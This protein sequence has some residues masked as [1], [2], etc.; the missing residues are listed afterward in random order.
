MATSY[1]RYAADVETVVRLTHLLSELLVNR[2]SLLP[3]YLHVLEI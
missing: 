3:C 2:R 1:V